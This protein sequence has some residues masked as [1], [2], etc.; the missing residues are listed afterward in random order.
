[1]SAFSIGSADL[2]TTLAWTLVSFLWQATLLGALA[3]G[4]LAL[5]GRLRPTT[6]YALSLVLLASVIVL[7]IATLVQLRHAARGEQTIAAGEAPLMSIDA[8]QPA[9]AA[10][11]A[12]FSPIGAVNVRAP[13]PRPGFIGG[14]INQLTD[15]WSAL[16]NQL[17]LGLVPLS[18]LIPATWLI[19]ALLIA[20]RLLLDLMVIRALRRSPVFPLPA[21]LASRADALRGR[22]GLGGRTSIRIAASNSVGVP[23]V[24]GVF[25][26]LVL[27]PSRL[28]ATMSE[29]DVELL[30]AHELAHVKRFDYAV[31]LFQAVVEIVFFFHPLTWWL[32]NRVRTEREHCCDNRALE[33]TATSGSIPRVRYIA[34]LLAAEEARSTTGGRPRLA[35]SS[36][37]R[38]LLRRAEELLDGKGH[39]RAGALIYATAS[40]F[41]LT[42][43][44]LLALPQPSLAVLRTK[45]ETASPVLASP[46]RSVMNEEPL[47]AHRVVWRGIVSPGAWLRVRNLVGDIRVERT[48][49]A[50]V[51][52]RAVG[53][54]EPSPVSFR[55][56]REASGVTVC[57]IRAGV[58]CDE[59][60]NV[61]RIPARELFSDSVT[62]L[63][64]L[65][66]GLNLL[67]ASSDGALHIAA[68]PLAVQAQTGKG[69][70][71]VRGARGSV[72]AATGGGEVR[73]ENVA[74]GL[75]VRSGGGGVM[76]L[77]V[78]GDAE[79]RASSGDIDASVAKSTGPRSWSFQ[80]SSGSIRLHGESLGEARIEADAPNGNIKS[81]F[82]Y[83]VRSRSSHA[84]GAAPE[85]GKS[86]LFASTPDGNVT[87]SGAR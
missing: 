24:L 61:S 57:A 40:A 38:A 29:E 69:E 41:A 6:R 4:T 33:M 58:E 26:P 15:R 43:A 32:S 8:D 67:A 3:W 46:I 36:S 17:L 54:R 59:N 20:G 78:S 5:C 86:F 50:E 77:A 16:Q 31:N 64:S 56:T 53:L 30:I 83:E 27:L 44:A 55:T 14:A 70:I 80:T 79:V 23:L 48:S 25:K 60:G 84:R 1:V 2:S 28:V 65:P 22:L 10:S 87:I 52:V 18:G 35:P 85:A 42:T 12:T 21:G 74:G 76:L 37:R 73:V 9:A 39:Q 82:A 34:A 49:G 45:L 75:V 71:T 19:G 47:D 7:P 63:V 72:E 68:R 11:P 13:A 66:D 81:D 51:E 62:L